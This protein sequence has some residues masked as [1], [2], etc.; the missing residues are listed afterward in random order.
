[1]LR[2]VKTAWKELRN[3]NQY[4]QVKCDE[5]VQEWRTS[6]N[7]SE[8]QKLK[9]VNQF[10]YLASVFMKDANSN[11]KMRSRITVVKARTPL[12]TGN[13][14]SDLRK[15]WIKCYEHSSIRIGSVGTKKK[16]VLSNLWTV[17]P[18]KNE[19]GEND[20]TRWLS[21]EDWKRKR[22]ILSS[23]I[24]HRKQTKSDT[25]WEVTCTLHDII[26]DG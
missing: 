9:N 19:K 11:R 6:A 1:M 23:Y 25:W 3:G 26:K 13:L 17:I 22:L 20:Q 21:V 4:N 14:N 12:L 5:S 7:R 8:K 24:R 10:R 18:D 16:D 15:K 2:L